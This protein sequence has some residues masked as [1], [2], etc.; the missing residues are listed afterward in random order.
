MRIP[1]SQ[2]F[3]A[4]STDDKNKTFA[5]DYRTKKRQPNQAKTTR[6]IAATYNAV[7]RISQQDSGAPQRLS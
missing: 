6:V 3:D 4:Y 1:R 5:A 7:V 2:T